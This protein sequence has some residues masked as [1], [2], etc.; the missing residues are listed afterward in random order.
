M[1]DADLAKKRRYRGVDADE[2]Q[3]ARRERLLEA[4]LE[5]FGTAGYT[6]TSVE[7][8]CRQAGLAKKFFYESFSDRES[9][10]LAVYEAEITRAQ[11]AVLR[12][13]AEAA[14][15]VQDQAAAGVS[16]FVHTVG[17]DPRVAR[18]VFREIVR[19]ATPAAEERYQKVKRDFAEF[20]GGT[21]TQ[22]QGIPHTKRIRMGTTQIIGAVNELMTDQ[23]LGYLDA[24]LDEIV[25]ITLTHVGLLHGQYMR[26]L[27]EGRHG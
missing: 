8:V 3:A 27:A 22:L 13:A 14:P 23:V 21:L 18:L 10:I 26:E 16:A 9:L 1:T 25:E 7:D 6:T 4:G 24:T 12:A 19:C 5:L 17:A 2:R 15:T 20:I 11:E